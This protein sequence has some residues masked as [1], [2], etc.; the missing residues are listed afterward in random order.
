M[1]PDGPAELWAFE[2]DATR[3]RSEVVRARRLEEAG[4]QAILDHGDDWIATAPV[5]GIALTDAF[6]QVSPP[7]AALLLAPYVEALAS[8]H[9]EGLVHGDVRPAHLL[10]SPLG[11]ATLI[12]YAPADARRDGVTPYLSPERLEGRDVDASADVWAVGVTLFELLTGERPF[13]DEEAALAAE[14]PPIEGELGWLVGVCLARDPWSRPRDARALMD[15][16][17][18]LVPEPRERWRA[19]R[20]EAMSDLAGYERQ[21]AAPRPSPE[22]AAVERAEPAPQKKPRGPMV[23]VAVALLVT[24]GLGGWWLSRPAPAPPQAPVTEPQTPDAGPP[25]NRLSFRPISPDALTNDDR[26]ETDALL[27]VIEAPSSALLG[28]LRRER[29]DEADA[30]LASDV[31]DDPDALALRNRGVLRARIGR[32]RDGYADLVLALRRR[33]DDATL[34]AEMA[35]LYTRT[36]HQRDAVPFLRELVELRPDMDAHL[37]LSRALEAAEDVE[38]AIESAESALAAEPDHVEAQAHYC[39]LLAAHERA[40][41]VPACDAAI[42][43]RARPMLFVARAQALVHEERWATAIADVDRAVELAPDEGR[44]YRHRADVLEAAGRPQDALSDYVAG[45]RLGDANAC[46]KAAVRGVF[47]H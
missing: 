25:S 34:H 30:L 7:V 4:L 8:L 26:P 22:P 31:A 10:T 42:R 3:F 11:D 45:C 43:A 44:Y 18:R 47:I 12:G 28:A 37:T 19:A 21:L 46:E 24:L 29:W 6:T 1:G 41:A 23:A 33:P 27:D 32:S 9:A 38:G 36:G 40:G 16:L 15:K 14:P 17:G 13:A 2:V 5:D 39:Q 35:G 20:R